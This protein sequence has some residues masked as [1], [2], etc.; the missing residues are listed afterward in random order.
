M[1]SMKDIAVRCGV[2]VATVSKALNDHSD[3]SDA[4]ERISAVS[5]NRVLLLEN[6][7]MK[8]S[9]TDFRSKLDRSLVPEG[10]YEYIEERGLYRK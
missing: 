9:S 1:V 8:L 4:I 3:I 6:A 10:V 2:S 7:R 5:P